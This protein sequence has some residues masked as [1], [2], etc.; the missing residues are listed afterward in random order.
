MGFFS[1]FSRNKR[2]AAPPPQDGEETGAA[3]AAAPPGEGRDAPEA[4]GPYT[5]D[6]DGRG[7]V[8]ESAEG[9]TQP[10]VKADG[11]EDTDPEARKREAERKLLEELDS[12]LAE[13]GAE[14]AEKGDDADPGA[15]SEE[16]GPGA[17]SPD[18]P[19]EMPGSA[20]DSR[21][22]SASTREIFG[23][24][25]YSARDATGDA[26]DSPEVSAESPDAAESQD[27]SAES[28]GVPA[29]KAAE[30]E[31]DAPHAA[32]ADAG[33]KREI[34]ESLLSQLEALIGDGDGEDE[35]AVLEA[36]RLRKKEAED[37][38]LSELEFLLSDED[39]A[40]DVGEG[41]AAAGP[42]HAGGPRRPERADSGQETA[43]A[44]GPEDA[45]GDAEDA[46]GD[47]EDGADVTGDGPRGP[48]AGKAEGAGA[49]SADAGSHV[50]AD[51]ELPPLPSPET[52]LGQLRSLLLE[53][54]IRQIDRLEG[55]VHDSQAL[56]QA[57]SRVITEAIL[58][59]SKRDDKLLTVL[60]PTVETIVTSSVRRSPETIA[61]QIFPV[62]GPAIR[63]F[64]SDTFMSMLQSL[65]STLEMSLSLKG[66][67]W[68][69]EA[70]RVHK[71]FSEIVMLHT[72]LYHVEEIYLIHAESGLI[73]DHIIYEG[74]ES[75][76]AELVAAMFTAI[77]DFIRDSFSVGQK[78]QLD[79][80]R[81]GERTI[82]LQRTEMVFMAAVVRGNPPAALGR[83][84]Q[85]ALELMAV[86]SAEDLERFKGDPAPFRKNRSFFQP[87]LEARYED[88]PRKLP[89]AIRFAPLAAVL[90]L[91]AFLG[92]RTWNAREARE[93]ADRQARIVTDVSLMHLEARRAMRSQADRVADRL[94]EEP[95]LSASAI[96]ELPGTGYEMTV[97]KDDL[98]ADPFEILRSME[99]ISHGS[100]KLI[101]APY[102]STDR[103]IVSRKVDKFIKVPEGVAH[104]FDN[105]SGTLKFSGT[106]SR[107]WIRDVQPQ[108][109]SISGVNS[110]DLSEVRDPDNAAAQELQAKINGT[111]IHFPMGGAQPVPEDAALF[112]ET[113]ANLKALG[114][115]ADKMG[116]APTL[117]LYGHAD[118]VGTDLRNYELSLE[119]TKTVA[120]R[121]YI[122]GS[123]MS[124]VTV[125][126][127]AESSQAE[128]AEAA[129]TG[130]SPVGGQDDA[131]TAAMPP[132]APP[133]PPTGNPDS[134][135]LEFRVR[136]GD[137]KDATEIATEA[138]AQ[139][140]EASVLEEPGDGETDAGE[141]GNGA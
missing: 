38:L 57:I 29:G 126:M 2:A 59:R 42:G 125:N 111:V 102:V 3:D 101:I 67:K 90:L 74:G 34:E 7:E 15:P 68:R 110:V 104:V 69:L 49:A 94:D 118:C 86:N 23:E 78:E 11:R 61:N 18:A 4:G 124:V 17:G 20:N 53:R 73:L 92:V 91:V 48:F 97:F 75:R 51:G 112:E 43:D 131:A 70:W 120:A 132:P 28:A 80:L 36:E 21:H 109:L 5:R 85:D 107:G 129:A 25:L 56:A 100:F 106:A 81:F 31:G 87:F 33:K 119:R 93:D 114:T 45:S 58:L 30:A 99:G 47:A 82:F 66:L 128:A 115:L 64:I 27:S 24:S 139:A 96:R 122:A 41:G 113:V 140:M 63:R 1:F 71:P 22:V 44:S 37:R 76:D 116:V 123:R 55:T 8:T 39:E 13:D 32:E 79:N 65:N 127:G 10:A 84:L 141:F 12:M 121:L 137:E 134:R 62:I 130:Q 16:T 35:A 19:S 46:S 40:E 133:C 88:K 77:R 6:A 9:W 135:R 105:D 95:G 136:L 138:A 14:D 98:A 108:A 60:G 89:F 103:E 52:E 26:D 50:D 83:D 117:T 54:E 72:L